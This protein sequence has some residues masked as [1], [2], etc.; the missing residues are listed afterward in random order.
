MKAVVVYDTVYGNTEQVAQG[1]AKHLSAKAIKVTAVDA[2]ELKAEDIVVFGCPTH[3]WNMSTEMKKLFQRLEGES[4]LGKKAATFDTKMKSR[5]AGSA[6]GKMVGKLKD[7]GFEVVLAP[8][9]FFVSGKEG[10][11]VEGELEKTKVFSNM[12]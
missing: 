4:F 1:I 5:L 9:S 2:A 10:P 12:Q 3:A 6:A 8:V 11:L 7:L